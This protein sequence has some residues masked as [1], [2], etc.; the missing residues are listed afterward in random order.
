MG[1]LVLGYCELKLVEY[2]NNTMI[3][4]EFTRIPNLLLYYYCISQ[5]LTHSIPKPI[6]PWN[7]I[8]T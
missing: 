2:S 3:D 1:L 5:Y 6:N 7:I 8:C 4:S